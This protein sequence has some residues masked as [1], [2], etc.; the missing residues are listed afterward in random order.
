M[1][2]KDRV[3]QRLLNLTTLDRVMPTSKMTAVSTD[4]RSTV[5]K[6][7]MNETLDVAAAGLDDAFM[8][9]VS[10][11]AMETNAFSQLARSERLK[12]QIA[13][14]AEAGIGF[15]QA[16]QS[17]V[18]SPLD[19]RAALGGS[20]TVTKVL[21]DDEHLLLETQRL[22]IQFKD[23]VTESEILSLLERNN[24]I[25]IE[26]LRYKNNLVKVA[27]T[28][29]S[30][31]EA[32][33]QLMSNSQIDY[34]E[35]DFIEYIG[36]RYTPSDPDFGNQWHLRNSTTAGADISAELAWEITKGEGV[37]L[38][39]IDNGFDINHPD[40]KFGSKSAWF[41]ATPGLDDA[42]FVLGTV[43]MPDQSHGTACAGMSTAVEGNNRGGC[44]VAFRAELM[45]IAC[46]GDQIGPQSTL[47]RAVAYAADPSSED[48]NL[49]PN[50]GAHVIACSLGPNGANWPISQVLSDA[51]DFA[52]TSG[53]GGKGCP[54]F[55]AC[56]NGNYPIS[57]DQVCS[58]PQVTAVGR[59]TNS[60][61]DN[62]S[63][64]GPELAF[65]APGVGVYIPQSG[66]GYKSQTGTSFA[67]PCAAG[68]GA[69][70]LSANPELTKQEVVDIM[71]DSCNQVGTLP[72]HGGRN[73][74][75]GNGRINAKAAVD[76]A[77]QRL[78]APVN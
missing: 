72:Y 8:S 16:T 71:K 30:S 66:G 52:A 73:D 49:S 34:A 28:A 2:R 61:S 57:A 33:L 46:L 43:G 37:R 10:N 47:A 27:T 26:K 45:A 68:V 39:V 78:P 64:F 38:A 32:S 29:P 6:N 63:G 31:V 67:G 51:I 75:F 62:G 40:L 77:V 36:A 1:P 44:G 42:D 14:F 56:T 12:V 18:D 9:N 55:W 24:L 48:G 11:D 20:D 23:D 69:L 21:L 59:S 35:P 3:E 22:I 5:A 50:D 41:R 74:R 60:D 4:V 76:I 65:L 58:H 19:T 15:F 70:V 25:L 17:Y 54:I 7:I 13:A 53:R